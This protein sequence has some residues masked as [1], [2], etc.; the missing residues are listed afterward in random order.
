MPEEVGSRCNM[1]GIHTLVLISSVQNKNL[2]TLKIY[3]PIDSNLVVTWDGDKMRRT[4]KTVN[5]VFIEIG[6][7]VL[8]EQVWCGCMWDSRR[9]LL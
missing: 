6:D 7:D 4:G 9:P 3:N 8:V 5:L 2:G 1:I